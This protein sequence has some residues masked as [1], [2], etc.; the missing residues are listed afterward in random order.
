MSL[1]LQTILSALRWRL[2]AA[3]LGQVIG[4]GEAVREY[5]LG[6]VVNQSLPG[7]M[8]GDAGR[9]VRTGR[10]AGLVRAGQA[11]VLERFAGQFA[12]AVVM[13]AAGAAATLTR[14]AD[15]PCPAGSAGLSSGSPGLLRPSGVAARLWRA[16]GGGV[17]RAA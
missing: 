2:T 10:R 8:V 14:R 15:W 3:R 11:V 13:I 4:V 7:G 6:Q 12:V 5:Y 16:S 9:A 17:G 1:T